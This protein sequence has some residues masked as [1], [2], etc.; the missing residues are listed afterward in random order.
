MD[1]YA[2]VI[3]YIRLLPASGIPS[4]AQKGRTVKPRMRS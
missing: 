2:S 3:S 4:A 1:V